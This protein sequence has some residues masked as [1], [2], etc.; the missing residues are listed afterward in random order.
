MNSTMLLMTGRHND[1][2]WIQSIGGKRKQTHLVARRVNMYMC[3]MHEYGYRHL[4]MVTTCNAV[5]IF[6]AVQL[7]GLTAPLPIAIYQLTILSSTYFTWCT[8]HVDM[9]GNQSS[10]CRHISSLS[11]IIESFFILCTCAI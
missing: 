3:R 9:T 11:S 8:V 6:P 7:H 5:H 4:V 2:M 1:Y 10:H